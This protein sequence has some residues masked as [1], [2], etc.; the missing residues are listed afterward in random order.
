LKLLILAGGY[1]TRLRSVVNKL[2]KAL[3]PI[4]KVPFLYYQIKNW[5]KQGITDFVFLLHFEAKLIIDF[6][7]RERFGILKNCEVTYI[8]EPKALGTGGAIHYCI[9]QLSL[10]DDFL[11]TNADTWLGSGLKKLINKNSPAL[12][13]VEVED[14]QRYGTVH[15]V[16]DK[17]VKFE[18]KTNKK[19]QGLINA[20]LSLLKPEYFDSGLTYPYSLEKV[21]YP[22]L[23]KANILQGVIITTNFIDIGIPEDYFK[24]IKMFKS[25][26][27]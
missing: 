21:I 23:V 6:L 17:V 12:L 18:E 20:G 7:D 26:E 11:V 5:K 25:D 13:I 24:F 19:S 1:G 14:S 2:P 9:N 27:I 3:A 22:N 4:N 8:I 15:L 16:N 10:K